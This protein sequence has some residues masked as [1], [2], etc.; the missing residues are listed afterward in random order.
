MV[1][2]DA[3]PE[4][5]VD[6]LITLSTAQVQL[7]Q[8]VKV[9]WLITHYG[10]A[11]IVAAQQIDTTH[12][13]SAARWTAAE[14]E[15]L[16]KNLGWISEEEIAT[17][18]SRTVVAVRLRWKRD[19]RLP[20]PS[21]HPD[22][23]TANQVA[24]MLG[25]DGHAVIKLINLGRLP[26]RTL[27]GQRN[28]RVV[29]RQQLV[30]WVINP[31]N[32]PYFINSIKNLARIEEPH[33]RR[34]ILLKKER[35]NDEWWTLA[36]VARHYDG[37][38]RLANKYVH[39][40]KFRPQ[41]KW[42]NWYILRSE[43][44][45][46]G[47]VFYRGKGEALGLDRWGDEGDA[48]IILARAIGLPW[49]AIGLLMGDPSGRKVE[50]H[51]Y[52]LHHR[53]EV[54]ELID[55]YGLKITY[56]EEKM[57]LWADWRLYRDRFPYIEKLARK[58]VKGEALSTQQ[59]LIIRRVVAAWAFYYISTEEQKKMVIPLTGNRLS[60]HRLDQVYLQ[61]CL[62]WVDDPLEIQDEGEEGED[63]RPTD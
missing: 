4:L 27:P 55:K 42:P 46:P 33:L 2:P 36:D 49:A 12:N 37:D 26:A 22:W 14:D 56:D 17:T 21:K 30:R 31:M 50:Q 23:I 25:I 3:T 32:W 39:D 16:K 45:K 51:F 7:S 24:K 59:T 44:L 15:F 13:T 6:D 18:L 54:R 35:W 10:P 38:P 61:I 34:L 53:G 48:F 62:N 58:F 20:S 11:A 8:G 60:R 28:I 29:H 63:E 57:T 43:A 1:P 19:L 52:A 41:L 5:F 47:L 9:G 40:G